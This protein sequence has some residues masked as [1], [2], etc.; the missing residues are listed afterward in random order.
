MLLGG[1]SP[2]WF[3]KEMAVTNLPTWFGSCSFRYQPGGQGAVLAL[4]GQAEPPGGFVLRLPPEVKAAVQVKGQPLARS[5]TGD[6]LLPTGTR[7][8]TITLGK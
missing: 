6:F 4:D 8:A 3:Q 2:D 7:A 5:P 1:V